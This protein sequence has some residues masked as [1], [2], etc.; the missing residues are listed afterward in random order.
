M[1]WRKPH[2]DAGHWAD[3]VQRPRARIIEAIGQEMVAHLEPHFVV[4]HP[5]GCADLADLHLVAKVRSE[6]GHQLILIELQG[7]FLD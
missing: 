1:Q 5:R 4:A 3:G 6:A 7:S 2:I